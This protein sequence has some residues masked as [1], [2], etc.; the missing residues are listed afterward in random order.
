MDGVCGL[1]CVGRPAVLCCGWPGFYR[2]AGGTVKARARHKHRHEQATLPT[3]GGRRPILPAAAAVI[4]KAA[5]GSQ[6]SSRQVDTL[7]LSLLLFLFL[8][9]LLLLLL[10]W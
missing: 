9:L 10:L 7:L 8:L 3:E 5:V 2:T 6:G 4:A 1:P